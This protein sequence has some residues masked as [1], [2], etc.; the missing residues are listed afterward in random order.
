MPF[1]LAPT[2]PVNLLPNVEKTPSRNPKKKK[3]KCTGTH[4]HAHADV[5]EASGFVD[6]FLRRRLVLIHKVCLAVSPEP[7]RKLANFLS[8]T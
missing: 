5:S 2:T 4:I 6:V 8:Q 7:D 3:K 1:V